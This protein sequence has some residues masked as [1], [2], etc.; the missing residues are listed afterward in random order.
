MKPKRVL[1]SPEEK[2]NKAASDREYY[3]KNRERIL[4]QVKAYKEKIMGPPSPRKT[5]SERF[6][7]KLSPPNETGCRLWQGS[8]DTSGYGLFR[9]ATGKLVKAHRFAW[10]RENGPISEGM[11]VCHRCDVPTCCEASHHFLGSIADNMRDRNQKGRHAHGIRNAA[12]KLDDAGVRRVRVAFSAG[13]SVASIA[14]EYGVTWRT[15]WLAAV[16]ISWRHVK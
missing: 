11:Q 14:R 16:G 3:L 1:S 12:A 15:V 8:I 9:R 13:A 6:T 5:E 4:G 2:A 10:E 7:A